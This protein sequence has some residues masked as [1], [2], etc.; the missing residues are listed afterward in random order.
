MINISNVHTS[1]TSLSKS[2]LKTTLTT[3][4]QTNTEFL[5]KIVIQLVSKRHAFMQA[6]EG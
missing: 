3:F 6:P 5:E 4:T 1:F 2:E